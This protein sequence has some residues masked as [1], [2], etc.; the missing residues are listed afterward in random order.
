MDK[1]EIKPFRPV[2]PSPAALVTSMSEDGKPNIITLGETFN[3][4]I[5]EPVIVGIAIAKPR[6]SHELISRSKEYVVNLATA[7]MV[8]KVD[9]CGTCSGREVDKFTEIGL[10]PVPASK[11]KPPL[12]AECRVIGVHEIGDHDLFLGEVVAE[13]VDEA[14]LDE[15][16]RIRSDALDPLCYMNGEYWSAGAK[17]GWHGFS[18]A[19]A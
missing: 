18:R 5:A 1:R 12:I 19:E 14:A 11:V 2:Y 6:Y 13:H 8:R 16:G 7:A 9:L 17:L 3:I 15:K 4:S 10:T